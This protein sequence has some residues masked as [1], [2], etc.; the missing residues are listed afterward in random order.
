M[1]AISLRTYPGIKNSR[2]RSMK[3]VKGTGIR[4]WELTDELWE[5]VKAFVPERR[6]DEN[7]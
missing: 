3:R 5:A 6:R 7:Q 2:K 4:S 1:P